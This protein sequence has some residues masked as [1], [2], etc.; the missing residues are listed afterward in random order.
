MF[1]DSLPEL[2]DKME[3]YEAPDLPQV[4]NKQTT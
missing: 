4:I 1:S 3:T 2:L